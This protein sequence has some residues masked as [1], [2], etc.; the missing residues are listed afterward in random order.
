M[1]I[2]VVGG[3]FREILDGDTYPQP[4]MG[5]SGLVAAIVASRFGARTVLASY[6]G[7]E[8]APAVLVMLAAAGVE[9]N[10]VTCL[11]GASG[12]FV[13]PSGGE[14]PWPMYRPAEAVPTVAPDIG[15]ARVYL[16][17]G[18]PDFD[19]VAAGW[20]VS[21][22]A[23]AT[24][25]WDRQGWISRARDSRAVLSSAAGRKIYLANLEEAFEEF[26][27]GS[28]ESLWERLPPDGYEAAVIK[29]GV[30]SCVLIDRGIG[31]ERVSYIEAF[32]VDADNTIGSG[33]VFAGAVAAELAKGTILR[34]AVMVGNGAA[35]AFVATSGDVLDEGLPENTGRLVALRDS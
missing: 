33:D 15:E 20:L 1:D 10:M 7:E 22:P 24:L 28:E 23:D 13:F 30:D 21:V 9:T 26:S 35:S 2:V 8:D 31:G 19:P 34:D 14:H 3:I 5:G 25:I 32:P 11:P 6:V 18:M 4:R 29:R 27:E 16:V 12:T 17:F